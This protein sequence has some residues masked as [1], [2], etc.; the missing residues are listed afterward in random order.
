MLVL[1][2]TI[3]F[4]IWKFPHLSETFILA[5][6][7][8]AIKC[9]YNV[10]I[11]V[12]DL[13]DLEESKQQDLIEKHNILDKIIIENY[14]IPKNKLGRLIKACFLIISNL[15]YFLKLIKY[16]QNEKDLNISSIFKFQF[17]KQFRDYEII[18]V[19]YGTNVKPVDVFKKIGL[20]SSKLVVTFHGHDAFF[21]INGII[22]NNG[23]YDNLFKY[24]DLIIA[25]TAYLARIIEELGCPKDKLKTIPVGVDSIFFQPL[26][27]QKKP[28]GTIKI[29]SVGRLD[30]VKGHI[31]AIE[32]VESL[33]AKGYK[34]L[35]RIVGEGAER[36]NLEEFIVK[37][38]L[39]QIVFLAGKK[40]QKEIRSYLQDNDIYILAAVPLENGRRETQGLATLEAQAC[41]LPAIV[42]DSGGVKYTVKDGVTGFIVPEFDVNAMALRIEELI[43]NIVL[44]RKMGRESVIY[45][46]NN[47]SQKEINN[48]WCQ[49]YFELSK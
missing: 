18:H 22:P 7:I 16:Y 14:Q 23:Y 3:L 37:N 28:S 25:N 21:P 38:R 4:K 48:I 30:K 45:V 42:F 13:L 43:K 36:N 8:I 49:T 10:K 9:G 39:E 19:Q 17:Y 29:I 12:E 24:G 32:A 44:R 1:R 11:L 27:I 34:I 35:L 6:I 26:K 2:K 47:F 33:L 20:L 40:N 46:K 5:Q 41:G 15:S 31:Y